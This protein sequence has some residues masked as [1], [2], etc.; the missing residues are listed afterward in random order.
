LT[1]KPFDRASSAPPGKRGGVGQLARPL[2]W[3][4]LGI[5][6]H[7]SLD[8]EVFHR[9]VRVTRTSDA[10]PDTKSLRDAHSWLFSRFKEFDRPKFV[11]LWDGRRGKLRN[12]PEFETA[13]KEVL[14]LVTEG[15]GE[16]ISINNTPVM[17]VQFHRWTR[18][19]IS[20]PIRAFN[21]EHL[22]LSYALE[23]SGNR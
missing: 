18:E 13:I 15:W 11:L 1:P 12:D 7:F 5:C 10:Y 9:I 16:F 4:N 19:G 21:D 22:A 3:K 2:T 6:A 8:L 23:A 14:P 17:T 20:C